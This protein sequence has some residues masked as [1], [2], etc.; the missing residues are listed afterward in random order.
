MGFF[1]SV[2]LPGTNGF[3]GEFLILLGG[4]TASPL[5]GILA[6]SGVI[7]GAAYMLWLYQ[8]V[9]FVDTNPGL[10]GHGGDMNVREMLTLLPLLILVFWIGIF[11]NTF[12]GYMDVSVQHLLERVQAGAAQQAAS[13]AGEVPR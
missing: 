2:G 8:K 10:S 12:L 5:A 7:I 3:I 11:P 13:L 9:F 1:A 4:F 6:A